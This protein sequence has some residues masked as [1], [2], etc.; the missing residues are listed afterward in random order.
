M[1]SVSK[2]SLGAND[3]NDDSSVMMNVPQAGTLM[4][5]NLMTMAMTMHNVHFGYYV[6]L[7]TG[8]AETYLKSCVLINHSTYIYL[9]LFSWRENM[10]LE[11]T[12]SSKL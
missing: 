1:S 2:G 10:I 12:V 9:F 4:L 11:E 7:P 5:M 3:D 8:Q 6:Y